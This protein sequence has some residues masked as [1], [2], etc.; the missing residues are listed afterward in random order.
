MNR[1]GRGLIAL[2]AALPSM[3]RANGHGPVYGLATPTLGAGAFS[4]DVAAMG[5]IGGSG[6]RALLRPMLSYGITQD[7]QLSLS[8]PMP[9]YTRQGSAPPAR[10]MAMMPATPDTEALI[11]WRFARNGNDVGSRFE[12]TAYLGFDYPTDAQREGLATSPGFVAGAV[13]GYASRSIYVWAGALYRRYMSPTGAGA[14][15]LGDTLFYSLVFGYRPPFFRKELP[16]PDW[17]IFVEAVGE[18]TF[19]NVR[20]GAEVANTGGDRIFVGPTLLGLFG[21]WGVSFGPMFPVVQSLNGAQVA[22]KVRLG[23]DFTYWF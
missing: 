18:H 6:D 1:I 19:A 22:E 20:G 15:H 21:A 2:A 5:R 11:G 13:T 9:L 16:S 23:V 10:M 8:L 7:L 4:L 14:D 12:S 3:A 17:R